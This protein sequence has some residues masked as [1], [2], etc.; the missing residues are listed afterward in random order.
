MRETTSCLNIAQTHGATSPG[1]PELPISLAQI[2]EV[3]R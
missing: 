1:A 3:R 2:S